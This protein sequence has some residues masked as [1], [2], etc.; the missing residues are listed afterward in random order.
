MGYSGVG[1]WRGEV[2]VCDV[3]VCG[4]GVWLSGVGFGDVG[5]EV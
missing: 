5:C 3:G 1:V 2:V 4:V